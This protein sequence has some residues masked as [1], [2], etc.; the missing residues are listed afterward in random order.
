LDKNPLRVSIK[1]Q[2][3]RSLVSSVKSMLKKHLLTNSPGHP[4]PAFLFLQTTLSKSRGNKAYRPHSQTSD[5]SKCTVR[6]QTQRKCRP[7]YFSG[8]TPLRFKRLMREH[9]KPQTKQL[10]RAT[11]SIYRNPLMRSSAEWAYF[12]DFF[13][14]AG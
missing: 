2:D 12:S 7:G 13:A 11:G 8:A 3:R 9:E 6:C 1:T 10:A 14:L 5:G 4:P